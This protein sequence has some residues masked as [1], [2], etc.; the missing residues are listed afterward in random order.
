MIDIGDIHVGKRLRAQ[1]QA[2]VTELADS[3]ARQG[4]LQPIVVRKADHHTDTVSS[5]YILLAGLHRLQAGTSLGWIQIQAV[6]LDYNDDVKIAAVELV[7]IDENL[8]RAELE[9]AEHA[10][11]IGRRKEIYE[12][13]HPETKHGAA[14]GKAGGGKKKAKGAEFASFAK[15][16]AKAT[17]QSKRTVAQDAKRAKELGELLNKIN[18]TSLDKGVEMDALAKLPK[19]ER[20][21]LVARAAKGEQVSAKEALAAKKLG[22]KP[23]PTPPVIAGSKE[24]PF[25]ERIATNATLTDAIVDEVALPPGMPSPNEAPPPAS[26]EPPSTNGHTDKDE[27][28]HVRLDKALQDLMLLCGATKNWPEL[29]PEECNQRETLVSKLIE[30]TDAILA[31]ATPKSTLH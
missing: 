25:E 7:E 2:K 9:P 13:L 29:S 23:K 14:P 6:V 16:T 22:A 5:K 28:F 1:N 8:V 10:A 31:L 20:E 17:G 19:E 3:M 4:Q 24:I 27:A 12:R 26:A 11:H 18:G 15:A 30:V 21:D